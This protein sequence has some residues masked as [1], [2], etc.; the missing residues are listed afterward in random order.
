MMDE[1]T[2]ASAEAETERQRQQAIEKGRDL[3]Q[4][5]ILV[6]DTEFEATPLRIRATG[7]Q[8]RTEKMRAEGIDP[9]RQLWAAAQHKGRSF[10]ICGND[11]EAKQ[12]LRAHLGM[13]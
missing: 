8:D 10:E 7:A 2:F 4:Y 11:D 5:T 6:R 3:K 1:R 12:M 9:N 13:R